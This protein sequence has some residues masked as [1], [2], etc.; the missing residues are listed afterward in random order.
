M[1]FGPFI[2]RLATLSDVRFLFVYRDGR[3]V[4][5]SLINWHDHLFGSVYR[6][7]ME[8]GNL[9][10]EALGRVAA[11]PVEDDTSDYARPRPGVDDIWFDRWERF[12]RFEMCAWYWSRINDLML[13]AL[14]GIDDQR[15]RWL[16]YT[17]VEPDAVLGA[18]HWCGIRGLQADE[19]ATMLNRRINSLEER[20]GGS[21]RYPGWKHWDD[22]ARTRFDAIAAPVM[23]RLGFYPTTGYTRFKPRRY[24]TWW[25]T[26]GK[27]LDWYEWMFDGRKAAHEDL[28]RFVASRDREGA[29]LQRVLDVGCGR[30]VG[31]AEY[32]AGRRFVGLDLS[33]KEIDWCRTHRN[34]PLHRYVSGDLLENE[35][36]EKFDLVYS[37][38]TIDNVYDID[39]YLAKMVELSS[40]WIYVTAYKGWFPNLPEHRYV[41]DPETTCY[42]NDVSAQRVREVL[43]ALGCSQISVVAL[44]TG[45]DTMPFETRITAL[46]PSMVQST[47][48]Q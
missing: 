39:S 48:R 14:Q 13:T 5:T 30:A 26:N 22:D 47:S 37:Q 6:E 25:Q 45:V 27:D 15:W 2:D 28:Q 42:Y 19:V 41:W 1:T 40:K 9:T 3:D 29:A 43:S 38:G 11:L 4:V 33:R 10:D 23:Q 21:G 36:D 16:N 7:C 44:E 12:S 35:F 31:Y 24:G 17:E 32:F 18:A 46:V 34:N 20:T 8:P